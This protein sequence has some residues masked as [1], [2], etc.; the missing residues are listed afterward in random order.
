MSVRARLRVSLGR[1]RLQKIANRDLDA[2]EA[3]QRSLIHACEEA[4][5]AFEF[6]PAEDV[7]AR[8]DAYLELVELGRAELEL[9]RG[10]RLREL[11]P[12]GARYGEE[13]HRAVLRRLS[14]F[15]SE[16]S[17][18]HEGPAARHT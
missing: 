1:Y 8:R 2:F 4:E 15:A 13:F 6:A 12:D 17:P 14:R 9:I 18:P 7:E 10:D 11:G 5:R 16:I 3:E